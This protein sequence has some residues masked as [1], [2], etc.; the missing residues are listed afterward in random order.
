MRNARHSQSARDRQGG[1]VLMALLVG[2]SI[3]LIMLARQLP[4]DAMS[5]QRIR[6][7]KLI[8][9]GEQYQRA[10]EL[11][12]RENKKYPKTLRDL[13]RTDGRTYLRGGHDD[14]MTNNG[15][16]RIIKMGGDG[17]FENSLLYDIEEEDGFGGRRRRNAALDSSNYV[18]MGQFRGGD[19]ARMARESD[20]PENP[21]ED[22]GTYGGVFTG[23]EAQQFD[24]DGNPIP[25]EQQ[26]ESEQPDYA[27]MRPG[28]VP[29][30][31]GQAQ[32]QQPQGGLPGMPGQ[33]GAFPNQQQPNS[34]VRPSRGS[35]GSRRGGGFGGFGG[36][37]AAQ[38]A[39]AQ[40]QQATPSTGAGAGLSGAGGNQASQLISRLLTTPRPG[41]LAGIRGNRGAQAQGQ[42]GGGPMFEEG[43]AGVAST[44]DEVGVKVYKGQ[45]NYKL[46]EFVYD[47]RQDQAGMGGT[48]GAP[49]GAAPGDGMAPG[50][51]GVTGA[52]G[53][54]GFPAGAVQPQ[55]QSPG[56]APPEQTTR[57]PYRD[58][59][60]TTPTTRGPGTPRPQPQPQQQPDDPGPMVVPPEDSSGAPFPTTV[61]GQPGNPF[62]VRPG[63]QQPGANTPQT[64]QQQP[65]PQQP[66][67]PGRSLPPSR[68]IG[69]RNNEPQNP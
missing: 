61:P 49:G 35:I 9:R 37:S 65:Q 16:W 17:R 63:P 25:S 51:P 38:Q 68:G 5:A 47:Y 7:Q 57:T 14:P 39:G 20:A 30:E 34:G 3:V 42:Q 6:E 64:P 66:Q 33:P 41:G 67:G 21:L 11:Y 43:I 32:P 54:S 62:P 31:A 8:Q 23:S 18:P 10:I 48:G 40:Q 55:D 44:A 50:Q 15:E 12:F 2:A 45:E 36:N 26:Q 53:L 19:R 59:R 24:A 1:Y 4:R 52:D 27:Q 58:P 13:E 56:M 46:W 28:Q 60:Q 29:V 69:R 22:Q